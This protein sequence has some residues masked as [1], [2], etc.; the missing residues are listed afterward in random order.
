MKASQKR[1]RGN[2]L[3]SLLMIEIKIYKIIMAKVIK[4]GV[5]PLLEELSKV[6]ASCAKKQTASK[7]LRIDQLKR[8]IDFSLKDIKG[9]R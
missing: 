7:Y 5:V 6:A 2:P 8:G 9:G 1:N 3:N 4:K